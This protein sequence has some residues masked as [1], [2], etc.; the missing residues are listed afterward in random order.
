M[1]ISAPSKFSPPAKMSEIAWTFW[2]QCENAAALE[3]FSICAEK[4]SH[5]FVR[6]KR[7]LKKKV[8]TLTKAS[9]STILRWSPK[10][11]RKGPS[12][13]FCKFSTCFLQHTRARCREPQLSTV[14]GGKQNRRFLAGEK[15]PE[16]RKNAGKNFALFALFCAYRDHWWW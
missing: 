7:D 2:T 14:F 4:F 6:F 13:E 3:V 1:V 11:K 9:F 16:I 12:F 15:T 8:I 10:K 5:L